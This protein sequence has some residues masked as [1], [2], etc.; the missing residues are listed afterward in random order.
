MNQ[1]STSVKRLLDQFK[2]VVAQHKDDVG[3]TNIL[4]YKINL[5]HLF[6]IIARP[7]SFDPAMQKKMKQEIQ[8]L[9]R[10]G[11]I[12][13]S[14]NPYSVSI[15]VIEKKNGTIRICSALIGL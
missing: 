4:K 3:R 2:D 5:I 11:I 1:L 10:R 6:P 13:P 15:S 14:T 12:H 9:L 8:D 7:K